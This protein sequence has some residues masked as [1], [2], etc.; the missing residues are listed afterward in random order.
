[1]QIQIVDKNDTVI[2]TKERDEIDYS[3]DIYRVSALWL[4]NSNG[5]ALIAKR[6]MAKKNSPGKWGPAVAG[7]LE[8]DETYETNIYKDGDLIKTERYK[9]GELIE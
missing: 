7:T 8:T 1:M 2:G 3:S 9:D 6:A 4:T 5:Q